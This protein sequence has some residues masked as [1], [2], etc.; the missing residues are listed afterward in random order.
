MNDTELDALLG[1]PLPERDAA[2]FSIALMERIAHDAARPARIASWIMVGVLF[3]IVTAACLFGATVA[4]Q[5]VLNNPLLIAPVLIG[6]TL[7]LS[8]AVFRSA[9]E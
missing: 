6:L 7:V 3:V 8:H 2:D 9:K 5:N 1:T 4:H